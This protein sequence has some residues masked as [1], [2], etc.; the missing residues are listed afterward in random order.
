MFLNYE[1]FSAY[2]ACILNEKAFCN[3]IIL[4]A[5]GIFFFSYVTSDILKILKSMDFSDI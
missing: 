3:F 2:C 1:K 4:C 5:A